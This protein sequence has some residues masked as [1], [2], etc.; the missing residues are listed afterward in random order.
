MHLI[1][2]ASVYTLGSEWKVEIAKLDGRMNLK[3][4]RYSILLLNIV[5]MSLILVSSCGGFIALL[6]I[7]L[8]YENLSYYFLGFYSLCVMKTFI[9]WKLFCMKFS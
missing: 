1:P 8:Q 6:I 4:F 3:R 5:F 9:S 2:N 7:L